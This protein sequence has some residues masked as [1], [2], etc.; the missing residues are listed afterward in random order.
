M[1]IGV[2]GGGTLGLTLGTR[3][4]RA[5]HEVAVLE[6][7]PRVG[8]LATWFDYGD[9]TWDKFY[10]VVCR[11][12]RHL[13]GLCD[14]LGVGDRVRW[15][16]TRTGFLWQGRHLSMSNHWEFLTFPALSL[17]QKMRLAAGILY[18]GRI[19]DPAPLE[20]MRA[21]DWLRR[22][23]GEGVCRVMWDPLLESK[24]GSLA[25]KM[26]ATLMWATINRYSS[27]RSK[28]GGREQLGYLSG[29]LKTLYDAFG[30]AL[31][32]NGGSVHCGLPVQ[33]LETD[34]QGVAVDTPEGRLRFDM[35]VSTVP[36]RIL[37]RMAP[38]YPELI[39]PSNTQPQFLG[40]AVMALVLRRALSP[41][42]VTNLLS[43]GWPFT[44]I[45]EVSQLCA[46]E[47][48]GG[49]HL[50]MLPRYDVPDAPIFDRPSE[51]IAAE[52]LGA[53]RPVFPDI[54][55]NLV[56]WF[57]HRE[58]TVQAMWIDAPPGAAPQPKCGRYGRIWNVNAE[59]AGRD[60]LNNN[61][62]V[63]VANDAAEVILGNLPTL[64]RA[65]LRSEA[66]G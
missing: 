63:R 53:L 13:L 35:V 36:T 17:Y 19:K 37:R 6:A 1:K 32:R 14:E 25:D 65:P 26:P 42:Y 47:E 23:F 20:R 2:V 46:P 58:R 33:G 66:R 22:V 28:G 9:F 45:I 30:G 64:A 27:T 40:V 55:D 34:E 41:Y 7:A 49:Q 10:H 16:E 48:L 38:D 52:F 21:V 18:C 4:A 60:T 57:V 12:D 56:R 54:D 8:G 31:H 44:G 50:V 39:G 3:L 62:I 24:Y 59:L 29:G 51:E 61:A 15:S 43:R 11:T 5:G